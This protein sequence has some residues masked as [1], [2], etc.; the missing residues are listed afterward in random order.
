MTQP[1]DGKSPGSARRTQREE[2]QWSRRPAT[3]E[4]S[5]L[6]TEID[7]VTAEQATGEHRLSANSIFFSI[8]LN[9][10]HFFRTDENFE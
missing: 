6:R 3:D 10:S 1:V 2:V 9:A 5:T 4:K 7:Q 8:Y